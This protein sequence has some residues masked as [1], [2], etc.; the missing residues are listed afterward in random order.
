LTQ[1]QRLCHPSPTHPH[2]ISYEQQCFLRMV[3][4]MEVSAFILTF[5]RAM[6]PSI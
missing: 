2:D 6:G 1:R 4:I 3:H 5:S